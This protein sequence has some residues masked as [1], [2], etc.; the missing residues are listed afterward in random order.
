MKRNERRGGNQEERGNMSEGGKPEPLRGL[1]LRPSAS[2]SMTPQERN[3]P[4]DETRGEI[5][6]NDQDALLES[7]FCTP[8]LSCPHS[9]ASRNH[10]CGQCIR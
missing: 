2:E 6:M 8:S 9:P 10:P 3:T 4:A 1:W 7:Y 5:A